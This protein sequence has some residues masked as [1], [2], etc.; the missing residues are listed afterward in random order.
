MARVWLSWVYFWAGH[1]VSRTIEPVFG[2]WF[3]WPYR[4]YNALMVKSSSLQ[5]VDGHGP[6]RH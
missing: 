4:L 6:W 3:E 5:S 2:H 1:F